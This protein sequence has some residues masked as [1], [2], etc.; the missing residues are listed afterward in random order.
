MNMLDRIFDLAKINNSINKFS[1]ELYK[2]YQEYLINEFGILFNYHSNRIEGVNN[3][4]TLNDIKNI[5]NNTYNF[6]SIIDKNKQ[7]EIN[8]TIN[9]QNAFKH[10]FE[11]LNKEIDILTM[12]KELHQIVGSGID[13]RS[14]SYKE[15]ETAAHEKCHLEME[16]QKLEKK[17]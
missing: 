10:I 13:D 16:A 17:N 9:H 8:E 4:L 7:R 15:H 1:P 6:E 14:G 2:K 3:N 11:C 12:I 5:L